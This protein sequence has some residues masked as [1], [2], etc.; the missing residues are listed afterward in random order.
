MTGRGAMLRVILGVVR[1][2][3]FVAGIFFGYMFAV[4]VSSFGGSTAAD[5]TGVFGG[6]GLM[7]AAPICWIAAARSRRGDLW[8]VGYVGSWVVF[9]GVVMLIGV[10]EQGQPVQLA[11]EHAGTWALGLLAVIYLVVLPLITLPHYRR[12]KAAQKRGL[13]GERTTTFQ[14]SVNG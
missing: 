12:R 7:F 4:L 14:Q 13:V 8:T 1:A 10:I 11:N 6:L 9:I 5:F 2:A 3:V